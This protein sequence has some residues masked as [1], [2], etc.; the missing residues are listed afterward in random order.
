LPDFEPIAYPVE[1]KR[2]GR[3]LVKNPFASV[4]TQTPAAAERMCGITSLAEKVFYTVSRASASET[5]AR[6]RPEKNK[7]SQPLS[8]LY[9]PT[10]LP[11]DEFR[12]A[13]AG[14]TERSSHQQ[15][16]ISILN[17]DSD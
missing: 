14:K 9:P 1:R 17:P 6:R 11:R 3:G 4:G 13:R 5:P 7:S 15:T 16:G 10:K 12:L 8:P 2:A